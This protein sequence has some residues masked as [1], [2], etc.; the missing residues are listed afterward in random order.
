MFNVRFTGGSEF[1]EPRIFALLPIENLL[2]E[3][4]LFSI[5]SKVLSLES[6]VHSEVFCSGLFENFEDASKI[7]KVFLAHGYCGGAFEVL[8]HNS[9]FSLYQNPRMLRVEGENISSM[10]QKLSSIF[11]TS[12]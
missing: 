6:N 10:I 11:A 2:Q 1:V 5:F 4:K 12:C 7:V 9:I 8:P 3:G